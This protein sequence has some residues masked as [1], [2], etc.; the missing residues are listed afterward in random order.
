M[1]SL[2][3]EFL[4]VLL[5]PKSKLSLFYKKNWASFGSLFSSSTSAPFF[6]FLHKSMIS[7]VWHFKYSS[8]SCSPGKEFFLKLLQFAT[9]FLADILAFSLFVKD[10]NDLIYLNNLI[11]SISVI[12]LHR[13]SSSSSLRDIPL[14]YS[15]F[16]LLLVIEI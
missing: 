10:S 3:S 7:G 6:T 2:E 1:S 13:L 12:D 5:L 16:F 8:E 9:K 4:G 14:N 11:L 15:P